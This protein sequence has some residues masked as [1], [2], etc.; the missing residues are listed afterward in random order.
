M[1]NDKAHFTVLLHLGKEVLEPSELA[2]GVV[3]RLVE[4][5]VDSIAG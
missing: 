1:S 5:I 4:L 3:W 2:A